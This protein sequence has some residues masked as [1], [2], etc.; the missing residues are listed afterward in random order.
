MYARTAMDKVGLDCKIRGSIR[1][2]DWT[3]MSEKLLKIG[4]LPVTSL[5][6]NRDYQGLLILDHG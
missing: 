2:Q 6:N 1:I 4:F 3:C 5:T